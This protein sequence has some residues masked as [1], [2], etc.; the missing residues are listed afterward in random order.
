M[1][2]RGTQGRPCDAIT[3]ANLALYTDS[4]A[5]LDKPA[6][7]ALM[8]WLVSPE[9]EEVLKPRAP[10]AYNQAAH[11]HRQHEVATTARTKIERPPHHARHRTPPTRTHR[12]ALSTSPY[13]AHCNPFSS[14]HTTTLCTRPR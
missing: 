12:R 14:S 2:S 4:D 1:T 7:H 8:T 9:A 3:E 11:F 13:T 6:A 10:I 5:K